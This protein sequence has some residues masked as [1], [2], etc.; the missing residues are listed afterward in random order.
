[1]ILTRQNT[2]NSSSSNYDN[3]IYSQANEEQDVKK[4]GRDNSTEFASSTR[5][6][7]LPDPKNPMLP[8]TSTTEYTHPTAQSLPISLLCMPSF[9]SDA[10]II[11]RK[12]KQNWKE[13][14]KKQIRNVWSYD[15][16]INLLRMNWQENEK[17][18]ALRGKNSKT[19][20]RSC[21]K[22]GQN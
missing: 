7:P 8:G 21:H 5:P 1:M 18:V 19:R 17:G 11:L 14:E 20:S 6:R 2:S 9:N 12:I 13:R 16:K 3:A 10:S 22:K 4:C 15:Q